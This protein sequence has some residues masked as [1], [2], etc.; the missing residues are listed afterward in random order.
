MIFIFYPFKP[1]L[2]Q[3]PTLS[4]CSDYCIFNSKAKLLG[5]CQWK[6]CSRKPLV[7]SL[8]SWQQCSSALEHSSAKQILQIWASCQC[9]DT[10]PTHPWNHS[11]TGSVSEVST[12]AEC[13]ESALGFPGLELCTQTLPWDISWKSAA[14]AP[15]PNI[16]YQT[17]SGLQNQEMRDFKSFCGKQNTHTYTHMQINSSMC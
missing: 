5:I 4:T 13:Q 8:P 17:S 16:V 12:E 11:F 15:K 7:C 2:S 14:A 9:M 1:C 6:R 10:S 3:I